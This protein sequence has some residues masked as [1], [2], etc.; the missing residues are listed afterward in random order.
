MQIQDLMEP[1]DD[2]HPPH[3]ELPIM[4]E[5]SDI[6]LSIGSKDSEAT[7]DGI[8]Q[9]MIDLNAPVLGL[10]APAPNLLHSPLHFAAGNVLVLLL[11]HLMEAPVLQKPKLPPAAED[12]D[13][14]NAENFMEAQQAGLLNAD[15]VIAQPDPSDVAEP[16][17][18][19]SVDLFSQNHT[20]RK[21]L[22]DRSLPVAPIYDPTLLVFTSSA[23]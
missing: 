22:I 18:L 1:F 17:F 23:G 12:L 6:T 5:N 7:Q 8:I 20:T 9:S 16:E 10:A 19:V 4:D 11:E 2:I 3:A 13:A 21:M 15:I 14:Q